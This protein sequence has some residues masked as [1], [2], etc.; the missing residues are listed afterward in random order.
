MREANLLW[1][2]DIEGIGG[3]MML[4]DVNGDGRLE[5]LLRQS[6]G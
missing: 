2:L 3:Q 1:E 5:I 4:A 6:P